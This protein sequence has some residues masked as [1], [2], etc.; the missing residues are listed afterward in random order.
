M[1]V[2]RKTNNYLCFGGVSVSLHESNGSQVFGCES[3]ASWDEHFNLI[4][5]PVCLSSFASERLLF[6]CDFDALFK[7][8]SI[9]VR[10]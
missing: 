3:F 6:C 4:F 2:K 7:K 5:A 10:K 9:F 8:I 1:E